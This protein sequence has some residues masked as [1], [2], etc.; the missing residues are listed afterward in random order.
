MLSLS[1][2]VH[3]SKM[4]GRF[5]EFKL[6]TLYSLEIYTL[7]VMETIGKFRSRQELCHLSESVLILITYF[8]STI[9]YDNMYGVPTSLLAE[10]PKYDTFSTS[11]P[12]T[13]YLLPTSQMI[14]VSIYRRLF[15]NY[16]AD[17]FYKI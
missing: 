12:T 4:D 13:Y 15:I 1:T 9:R 14:L 17:L 5:L 6:D 2:S 11:F 10:A 3:C 7:P 8:L 16:K